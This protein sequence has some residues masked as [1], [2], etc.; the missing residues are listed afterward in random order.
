MNFGAIAAATGINGLYYECTFDKPTDFNARR[1]TWETARCGTG[2]RPSDDT[3]GWWKDFM[4]RG[5]KEQTKSFKSTGNNN[6]EFHVLDF[7]ADN[8]A[9]TI[10]AAG[11]NGYY[12][13]CTFDKPTDFN[14][15]R[16]TCTKC[17]PPR[18]D[19]D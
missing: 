17:N 14:A 8:T 3:P 11:T 19:D 5:C 10:T 16:P 9:R 6:A 15:R 4:F 1:P 7:K 13:D 18:S 12:Y 2:F